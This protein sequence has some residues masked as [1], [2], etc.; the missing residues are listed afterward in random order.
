MVREG[1]RKITNLM[2]CFLFYFIQPLEENFTTVFPPEF[3]LSAS[4]LFY[5]F[6]YLLL[7]N[8]YMCAHNVLYT[9]REAEKQRKR[10]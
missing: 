6:M 1:Q 9:E 7:F 3:F 5:N 4:L 8:T 10:G 2:P